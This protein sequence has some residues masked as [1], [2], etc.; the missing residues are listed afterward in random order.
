M[1]PERATHWGD[2]A[3]GACPPAEHVCPHRPLRRIADQQ[4]RRA[5]TVWW[6]RQG[7]FLPPATAGRYL[8]EWLH[9]T[10]RHGE[11]ALPQL[12]FRFFLL[13][14]EHH[15]AT[16]LD[17]SVLRFALR[18]LTERPTAAT[19]SECRGALR[20]GFTAGQ[21]LSALR[22]GHARR[23]ADR[24]R[25]EREAVAFEEV[26]RSLE[27]FSRYLAP[28]L[29]TP[30]LRTATVNATDSGADH[31]GSL[32][33]WT[34]GRSIALPAR[35]ALAPDRG[36]NLWVY[37]TLLGHE[38]EHLRSGSF[39]L[40]FTTAVGRLLWRRLEPH[41]HRFER[42]RETWQQ[43]RTALE[44]LRRA[45]LP[46]PANFTARLPNLRAFLL[47]L[48]NPE[49]AHGLFNLV[50]DARVNY[51]LAA[52][53]P[54][55]G[56]GLELISRLE[57]AA[58]PDPRF[59]SLE[60][61]FVQALGAAILGQP[62]RC[63][64]GTPFARTWRMALALIEA[65]RCSLPASVEASAL[66]VLDLV[67]LLRRELPSALSSATEDRLAA[68]PASSIEEVVYAR[69]LLSSEQDDA[70]GTWPA[71][72]ID[73]DE[74]DPSGPGWLRYSEFDLRHG[75]QQ[76][77]VRLRVHGPPPSGAHRSL[78]RTST[79]PRLPLR[80][81]IRSGRNG[82]AEEGHDLLPEHAHDLVV[83][84]RLGLAP[85][86]RVF[87][88]A[89]STGPGLAVT[90]VVDLS[91]S[92]SR[93]AKGDHQ[94]PLDRAAELCHALGTDTTARS[95]P[96]AI[97][98]AVDG[99]RRLAHL[100]TVKPWESRYNPA[101]L[102]TL[103]SVAGG[104]FRHGAVVRH[105]GRT[106]PRRMPHHRHVVVLLTD[107]SSH[108]LARGMERAFAEV[109]R[110]HCPTCGERRRCPLEPHRFSTH[111]NGGH[112]IYLPLAYELADLADA[113]ATAPALSA[114]LVLFGRDG[115][116][117][118]LDR[119]L[120]PAGWTR[121]NGANWLRATLRRLAS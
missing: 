80:H 19:W 73:A 15:A 12:C 88:A 45:G 67:E 55:L 79:A 64:V 90:A 72:I 49:A 70:E 115:D 51:I 47:H 85:D 71:D 11:R 52:R 89:G 63:H 104:G 3:V 23:R 107:T 40:R 50:E 101:T 16:P 4:H 53:A 68:I 57:G 118:Q 103:R 58:P 84:H 76:D 62:V 74:V 2:R 34:D 87:R 21:S 120:G 119:I 96:F 41:R 99:S 109:H 98:G 9:C 30:A 10:R 83:A 111:I 65:F 94:S 14:G 27:W 91:A 100:F 77:V 60:Q 13:L 117:T 121:A 18:R 48:P 17:R 43:G 59:H 75:L 28:D 5:A 31:A 6:T 108:Y 26:S 46:V 42:A 106:L 33:A 116:D 69:L 44:N 7:R 25:C 113:R 38:L 102:A 56:S 8:A 61:S 105:L 1:S 54:G 35:V 95:I 32:A 20:P 97:L 78:P 110:G 93:C 112:G 39:R 82:R 36:L 24:A 22:R 29:L 114:H 66:L 37:L 92:M 86:R 81:L